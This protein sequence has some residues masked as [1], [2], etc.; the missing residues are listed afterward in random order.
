MNL[1]AL[2]VLLQRVRRNP[3]DWALRIRAAAEVAV[4]AEH[5]ISDDEGGDRLLADAIAGARLLRRALERSNKTEQ[6]SSNDTAAVNAWID[7]LQ[8]LL[9]KIIERPERY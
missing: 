3:N 5:T 6:A 9:L 7:R 8:T 2:N 4:L 1:E